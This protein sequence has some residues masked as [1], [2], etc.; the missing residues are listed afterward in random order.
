MPKRYK[1][2][3]VVDELKTPEDVAGY[4]NA[5]LEEGDEKQLMRALGDAVLAVKGMSRV[6]KETGLSRQALYK[7]LSENGNPKVSSLFAV[8]HSVGLE[9][10]VRPLAQK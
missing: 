9:F 2:W 6:A 3:D 1:I 8:L 4:L 5:V 7:G 10:S